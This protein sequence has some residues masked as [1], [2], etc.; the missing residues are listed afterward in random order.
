MI[1]SS[2]APSGNQQSPKRN[3][4]E[5]PDGVICT[6]IDRTL[7]DLRGYYET[8]GGPVTVRSDKTDN[9]VPPTLLA[10]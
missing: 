10:I 6:T 1:S 7:G 3:E 2:S 4:P 9:G 8:G 5:S